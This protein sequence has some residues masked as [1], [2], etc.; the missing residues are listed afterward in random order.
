MQLFPGLFIDMGALPKSLH[1]F[2]LNNPS[3]S[4]SACNDLDRKCSLAQSTSRSG[5]ETKHKIRWYLA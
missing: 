3:I 4:S 2:S 5:D 1:F